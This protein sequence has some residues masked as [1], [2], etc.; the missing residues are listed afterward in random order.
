MVSY[1]AC[2]RNYMYKH[3]LILYIYNAQYYTKIWLY[4]YVIV[5]ICVCETSPLTMKETCKLKLF[6]NKQLSNKFGNQ[7]TKANTRLVMCG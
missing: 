6:Q 2:C 3:I 7:R 1:H 4:V 5:A